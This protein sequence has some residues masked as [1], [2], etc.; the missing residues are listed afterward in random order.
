[1]KKQTKLFTTLSAAAL[2]TIGVSAVSMAAGWDNSTGEWRYLNNDGTEVTDA[3]KSANGNWF[4]LNS[5][6][7]M[8]TNQLIEDN[9]NSNTRYY[10]VDQYGAMV[11]NTWKAVAMDSQDSDLDAEYW[12]YYFGSDGRAYT[13]TS[14]KVSSSQIKTIDGKKYTFDEQGHMLYGWIDADNV[15]QQDGDEYAWK[16]SDYFFNGWNDGHLQTG[17]AQITVTDNEVK[18]G[19]DETQTYWFSFKNDGKKR[20]GR[21]KVN[22]SY[23]HFHYEDGHMLTDW[24]EASSSVTTSTTANELSFLNGDGS[25][26]KNKWVWAI[27]DENYDKTDYDDDEY[28]WWYFNKSGSLVSDQIKKINGKKYAFDAKGK[29]LKGFVT[30]DS[31]AKNVKDLGNPDD[32]TRANVL[33]G[34]SSKGSV[35]S[36]LYFF[37]N[38]K[39]KDGSMKKGYQTLEL[40]DMTCQFYFNTTT[41]KGETGYNT[42]IKKYTVNGLVMAPS[43]DDDYNYA[44]VDMS[45]PAIKF[46]AN[47]E[48]YVLVN[49]S[50]TE[51]KN[52]AKLK[53]S[54]DGYYIVDS[55]GTVLKY[56]RS[57]TEY[58]NFVEFTATKTENGKTTTLT[59]KFSITS[60]MLKANH[61][62]ASL[63]TA[64]DTQAKADLAGYTITWKEAK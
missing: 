47:T 43:N 8:A 31:D 35:D 58:D 54:N 17:W 46:G 18:D 9:S 26:R 39:E 50:G 42:K 34:T 61:D 55:N 29:M 64:M 13:N 14:S 23:Y 5:D 15:A 53:D 45:T 12:W 62:F 10:Y 60:D 6:G 11:K 41:G 30:A 36:A 56:F 57:E 48:G 2:L 1:M 32:W 37:S 21:K 63:K 16:H 7:V 59:K 51:V 4:Y 44:G 40:D 38:D 19:E 52:K 33:A 49:K 25:E 27:P 20:K 24:A 28:S 22:G 3:W